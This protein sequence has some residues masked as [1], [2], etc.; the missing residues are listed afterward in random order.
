MLLC[1]LDGAQQYGSRLSLRSAGT[2]GVRYS[3]AAVGAGVSRSTNTS[4]S[5]TS[6][7]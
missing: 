6:V 5:F 3:A 2:T 4:P 1:T 7:L